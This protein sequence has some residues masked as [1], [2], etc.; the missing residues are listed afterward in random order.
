MS[1]IELKTLDDFKVRFKSFTGEDYCNNL[2][3]Y[4]DFD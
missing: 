3:I 4:S 2:T 1:S